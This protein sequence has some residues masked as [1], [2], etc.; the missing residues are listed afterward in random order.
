MICCCCC[1]FVFPGRVVNALFVC[2]V[3]F[4]CLFVGCCC[5]LGGGLFMICCCCCLFV[6][7]GRGVV[8]ALFGAGLV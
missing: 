5:C 4:V 3:F 7:P 6:F 2:D 1:L 8:D